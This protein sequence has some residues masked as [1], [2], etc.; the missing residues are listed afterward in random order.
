MFKKFSMLLALL[1]LITSMVP[2][3]ANNA[4]SLP[5]DNYKPVIVQESGNQTKRS[6]NAIPIKVTPKADG[7]GVDVYVGNVGVD[8][9][10]N[11]AVKVTTTG[12]SQPKYLK[13]YVP[14]VIGRNFSFVFPMIK[15]KTDYNVTIEIIDGGQIRTLLGHSSLTYSEKYLTGLWNK[16]TYVSRQASL[17][18]H[19]ARHKTGSNNLLDYFTSAMAFR[20]QVLTSTNGIRV[21]ASPLPTPA[22]KYT[23]ANGRFIILAN[24][25][26]TVLTF[27]K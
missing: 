17:E 9:L 10:D 23:N 1:V 4:Y 21:S 19:Y 15:C 8:G 20:S 11:V 22:K 2:A 24:S 26:K 25:D 18:D 12:Y 3:F 5:H 6:P 13:G 16:G 7:S 27:A 14:A